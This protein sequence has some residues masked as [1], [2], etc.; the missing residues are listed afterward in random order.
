MGNIHFE[1][2]ILTYDKYY[3]QIQQFCKGDRV[4]Y[5]DIC[6]TNDVSP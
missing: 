3:I 6:V 4:S 1:H 5:D 2:L